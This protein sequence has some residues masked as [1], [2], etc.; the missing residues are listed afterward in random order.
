[1][2]N[3]AD[4]IEQIAAVATEAKRLEAV[5]KKLIKPFTEGREMMSAIAA[6]EKETGLSNLGEQLGQ[7]K[8]YDSQLDIPEI[9]GTRVVKCL[10]QVNK[11]TGE[12]VRENSYVRIPTK[13]LTEEYILANIAD[14]TPYFLD[15][16]RTVE[17]GMIRDEH[18][19]GI[20]QVFT[21]YLSLDKIV[22]KLE[23]S[24]TSSRLNKE[25]IEAWFTEY[26]ETELLTSFAEKL[27]IDLESLEGAS[28]EKLAR[29]EVVIGAYKAKFASLASGKVFINEADCTAMIGVIQKCDTKESLI[30]KRFVARLEKMSQKE[31]DLLLTL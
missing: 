27:G 20:T 1:M 22:E 12:K 8:A 10:Y 3:T 16:L 7:F 18:K 31:E 21:E 24:A 2:N 30:G 26:V 13:H 17:D 25:K 6:A 9:A 5:G 11:K 28:E 15:Y 29:L 23:E 4:S 19:A 14:L